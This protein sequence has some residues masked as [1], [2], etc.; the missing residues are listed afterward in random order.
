MFRAERPARIAEAG[1]RPAGDVFEVSAPG[2][3]LVPGVR[4]WQARQP[5]VGQRV[6]ADLEPLRDAPDS[7]GDSRSAGAI[8][9]EAGEM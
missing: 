9:V 5:G 1:D 7:R 6:G 4:Y 8:S 3:N 2:D